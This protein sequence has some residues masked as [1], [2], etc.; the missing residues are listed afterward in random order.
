MHSVS[1]KIEREP[2]LTCTLDQCLSWLYLS[3]Y[4]LK[5]AHACHPLSGESLAPKTKERVLKYIVTSR[6]ESHK[7][8][9]SALMRAE[10]VV[11]PVQK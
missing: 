3:F 7:M 1:R 11:I 4:H 9:R 6:V 2:K 5:T 10:T 8:S